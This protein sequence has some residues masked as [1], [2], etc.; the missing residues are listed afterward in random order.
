MRAIGAW[1]FAGGFTLGVK[2]HFTVRCVLEEGAF[3]VVTARHN[4]PEIPVHVGIETWPLDSLKAE[5]A[6]GFIYG[7]PPCAAWSSAGGTA[8]QGKDW[9]IDPRVKCTRRLFMLLEELTP[10][11]WAWESVVPAFTRG[12]ELV[13]ELTLRALELGY[14]VTY[15]FHNSMYLGVPQQ[16]RRF[17]M[18]CSRVKFDIADEFQD[19]IA[20]DVVLR[21]MNDPGEP[22]ERDLKRFLPLLPY[23]RAGETM[24]KAWQRETPKPWPLNERG[25]V[26]GRPN[27]TLGRCPVG[28]PSQV[29]MSEMIHPTENRGLSM[30]ELAA[31]CGYPPDYEFIGASPAQQ[32]GRGVCPPVGEWL[33]RNVRRCIERGEVDDEPCVKSIDCRDPPMVV[34]RLPVPAPPEPGAGDKPWNYTNHNEHETIEIDNYLS[35][36][37]IRHLPGDHVMPLQPERSTYR[38]ERALTAESRSTISI[39]EG[40]VALEI[41]NDLSEDSFEDA[42]E[43]IE[44]TLK[45]IERR[46]KRARENGVDATA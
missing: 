28:R 12:R 42:R 46:M 21:R 7:N 15:L 45:R 16:R 13:D 22:L 24:I 17:F 27:I 38:S 1:I 19:V 36:S 33:A 9:R 41:P 18:V 31:L 37:V 3:G 32:L 14:S 2:E 40:T 29:I 6:I 26:L 35:S 34:N 23:V 44:M 20:A 30:K 4:Q 43:F 5:G 25:Q 11:V 10:T 39:P 8:I